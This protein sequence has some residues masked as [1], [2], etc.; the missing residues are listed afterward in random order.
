MTSSGFK[1]IHLSQP[2]KMSF[3]AAEQ[4]LTISTDGGR[5]TS[6]LLKLSFLLVS[7]LIYSAGLLIPRTFLICSF[8]SYT[9]AL[10]AYGS[11]YIRGHYV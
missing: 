11:T 4:Q 10:T 5:C 9:S 3:V 6:S 2:F 8:V 1:V 7:F